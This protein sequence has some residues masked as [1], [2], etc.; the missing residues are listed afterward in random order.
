MPSP[1]TP[2]VWKA[3]IN[4]LTGSM[5]ERMSKLFQTVTLKSQE[6]SYRYNE[7]GLPSDEYKADLCEALADC[8]GTGDGDGE[9]PNPNMS[10]PEALTASD[11]SYSDKI[12][13]DWSP[14]TGATQYK[15]Y[16]SSTS[17]FSGAALI[18]TITAPTVT[19]DDPVDAD[20]IAGTN[21]WYWARA[22]DGTNTSA[23]SNRDQG[24]AASGGGIGELDAI[25]DLRATIGFNYSFVALVWT[26]PAGATHYDVWR[27][28]TNVFA[29]ATKIYS[30]KSPAATTLLLHPDNN[31]PFWDNV[32]EVVLYDTPPSATTDYYYWVVAERSSPPAVSPESNDALGRINAPAIYNLVTEVLDFNNPTVAVPVGATKMWAV[33]FGGGGGGAGGN[34]TYGGGAGGGGAVV[35]EAFTVVAADDIDLVLTPNNETTGNAASTIG[36][37]NGTVAVL[38][39]NTVTKITANDGK[40]GSFSF[41]GGGAGGA[42]STGS[43]GTTSPTI[44]EGDAGIAGS[45]SSGGRSGYSFSQ[46]RNPM[47]DAF[48]D[49]NGDGGPAHAG[50]GAKAVSINPTLSV[51][52]YGG[53]G[54]VFLVFGS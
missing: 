14:V 15:L 3:L 8:I 43:S 31:P 29:A 5:C 1:V 9:T 37:A 35:R 13:I 10:A 41:A 24:R 53:S 20:L 48:G 30:D 42:G 34:E 7:A 38:K 39:I 17:S 49:F 23:L 21:Y 2:S 52:G 26:P 18:A 19:Y 45:G 22:T 44:Y 32:G 33:V 50:S 46:R 28:T 51:G 36:G 27:G 16:R 6:L 4:S 40:G 12:V 47:A 54:K 25:S 11:D